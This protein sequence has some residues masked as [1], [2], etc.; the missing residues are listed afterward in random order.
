V[1]P[2]KSGG[3]GLIATPLLTTTSVMLV[4]VAGRIGLPHHRLRA[5]CRMSAPNL[6]TVI[7]EIMLQAVISLLRIFY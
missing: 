2:G 3:L 1:L 7:A 5:A 4:T 6:H